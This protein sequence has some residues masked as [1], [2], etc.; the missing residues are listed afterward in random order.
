MSDP[1]SSP[2]GW[3]PDPLER[4]EHRYFNGSSWTSDVSTGGQ[5]SVDPLGTH[6]GPVHE[7]SNK[8]ATAAIVMGSISLV[9][10]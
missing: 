3:F 8:D 1:S 5:R 7:R 6:P 10:S 4:Y 2:P 9:I